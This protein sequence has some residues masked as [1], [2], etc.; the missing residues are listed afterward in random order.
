MS[1]ISSHCAAWCCCFTDDFYLNLEDPLNKNPEGVMVTQVFQYKIEKKNAM[2]TRVDVFVAI[3]CLADYTN[4]GHISA[5]LIEDGTGIEYTYPTVTGVFQNPDDL[6]AIHKCGR[7][8]NE[9][10]AALASVDARN[11]QVKSIRLHFPNGVQVS[12]EFFNGESP[13]NK[14]FL[15]TNL[16]YTTRVLKDDNGEVMKDEDDKPIVEVLPCIYWTVATDVPKKLKAGETND[17]QRNISSL[18]KKKCN[19]S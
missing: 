9:H 17:Y 4:G 13:S 5:A 3:K 14:T 15:Q 18:F 19:A 6:L 12:N 2:V 1:V 7:I 16:D 10:E 11:N 8:R